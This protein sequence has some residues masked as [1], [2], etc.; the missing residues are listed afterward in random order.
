[1]ETC[2]EN[3]QSINCSINSI[4]QRITP[5]EFIDNT[6]V[7]NSELSVDTYVSIDGVEIGGETGVLSLPEGTTV[8]GVPLLSPQYINGVYTLPNKTTISGYPILNTNYFYFYSTNTASPAPAF[9]TNVFIGNSNSQ[10]TS[11]AFVPNYLFLTP[12]DCILTSLLFSFAVGGGTSTITNAIA[13]IYTMSTTNTT[14]NTGI[15]TTIASCPINTRNFNSI[16]FQYPIAAGNRV[17]IRVSFSGTSSSSRAA[18]ATLG[19]KFL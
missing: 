19:Y 17:G 7:I 12:S 2:C 9:S 6:M 5:I 4:L 15:S 3:I 10:S 16:N 8:G 18:F 13:T 14:T 1:M 11:I